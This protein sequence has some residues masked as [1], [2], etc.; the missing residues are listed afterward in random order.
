MNIVTDIRVTEFME[1]Y[2][3]KV[4]VPPCTVMGIERNGEVIGG[5]LF[6][7]FEG[8][9]V[10]F[11]A[12]G[13]GFTRGFYADV[14]DYV[15]RQ[16]KCQRMTAITEHAKVVRLAERLGGKIEG[17]LRNHFGKGRDGFLI[18]ILRDEYRF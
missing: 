12:A 11:S 17:C 14:G 10:H 9:D 2:L 5:V 6:N 13:T 16:L 8:E 3:G 7:V 4:F 15:F 18:G 1:K